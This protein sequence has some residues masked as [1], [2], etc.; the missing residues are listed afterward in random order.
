M[1]ESAIDC[2]LFKEVNYDSNNKYPLVLFHHG[3]GGL[4]NDNV[5]NLES[6]L[7]SEWA[8]KDRQNQNPSFILAPQ[9]PISKNLI[10]ENGKPRTGIMKVHIRSIHEI[11]DHLEKEFPIDIKREYVTG[12]SMGGECA[13][14]SIIER[15]ER[16][17]AAVPI[18]GGDWIID[19]EASAI[20]KQFSKFPLWLF[21]GDEDDVVSVEVSRKFVKALQNNGGTPKYTEYKGVD[22]D[23][24]SLAY[25][26]S[27]MI[28]W[29]F[30]QSK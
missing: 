11:I 13:W 17:A 22:H 14:L 12:L 25:R 4:G 5:R 3:A 1:K 6:P 26:D 28:N 7:I 9:I 10:G 19:K 15:P 21:H 16:F 27:E 8:G 29:F 2:E 24:W 20:G 23:S 18:C 30:S